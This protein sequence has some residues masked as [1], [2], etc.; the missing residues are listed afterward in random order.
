LQDYVAKFTI[1]VH[2][3]M[4]P[5]LFKFGLFELNTG[6]RQLTRQGR[7]IRLQEQPFKV[8]EVLL[9]R[10]GELVTRAE[11]KERL[12]PGGVYVDFELGLNGAMKRLR[13]AL[14]DSADNPR[15]IETVH[16]S[17]Y[18][19]LAPVQQSLAPPQSLDQRSSEGDLADG[20]GIEA[21]QRLAG[22]PAPQSWNERQAG[23]SAKQQSHK[24]WIAVCLTGLILLAVFLLRPIT[25]APRVA[26]ITKLSN[27]GHA[28]YQA[29]LLSDGSR[30]YYSASEIG[31]GFQLRQ[32]LLN[33]NED[34]P[35]AGISTDTIITNLSPDG[36]TF[37]GISR[38]EI[39]D[40]R[41]S[42]LWIQPVIGGPTRRLGN[43]LANDAG[44]SS[45]GNSL[46][47][48]H[49]N[50][51]WIASRDGTA[52]HV[53]AT[54]RG[55]V[56][57]PRWSPD[58]QRIRFT[59][60][61]PQSDL[62]I[63]E[64]N[65][66]GSNL[67]ALDFHWSGAP[68]ESLGEWTADGRFYVFSSRREGISNLWA[69]EEQ[70][71]WLHRIRREPVQL[72]SGP[73]N[74]SRPLPSRDGTRIFALG[75]QA[76]GELL[77]YDAARKDFV[78]YL[79][80]LSAD[81]VDFT[82]DGVWIAYIAYPEGTLWRAKS[83]GSQPLQLTFPPQRALNPRWS[84]DGKRILFVSRK[85]GE[86]PKIYTISSDGGNAEPVISETHAQTSASWSPDG[87]FIFYGRDPEGEKQDISLY[88]IDLR[89]RR[90]EKIPAT[91]GLYSP[92][93]SPDGR[94][95]SAQAPG[96]SPELVL[97]NLQTMKR[98]VLKKGK[99]DYPAWAADSRVIY[100]NT[101][102]S[103]M[104]AV[105]RVG[106]TD[107]KIQKITD[108]PFRTTGVYGSWSGLAPDGSPLLFR[109]GIQTDVYALR[110]Q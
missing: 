85:P 48:A 17:G 4:P 22:E 50:Q 78:R 47:F 34:V 18:R 64:V 76:A 96:E 91:D 40:G 37:L 55:N 69:I 9:E 33:G 41:P 49:D 54:A 13:L 77:R 20:V 65:G 106:L 71:D 99:A 19:F 32:I 8:L 61:G 109:S 67:H 88:Q 62:S 25:P 38:V 52:E 53:L 43:F 6:T 58:G 95:L 102:T 30:L 21:P 3:H 28:N 74:Y 100:F 27:S 97:Y 73:M 90:T 101:F 87:K 98:T 15:F 23:R 36:T 107:G 108:L 56:F 105:F 66:D 75:S 44:W 14:S 81:Q 80:G 103:D 92:I 83:D 59:V 72:T 24:A 57:H 10:P 110:L 11:L 1:G 104:P 86:L 60:E 51:L 5:L 93:C 89:N 31:T 12:W 82:R 7:R 45:D 94:F 2:P 16:K 42:P 79:G 35:V 63:W 29:N 68:S 70:A 84:P 39:K 26:R 46:A